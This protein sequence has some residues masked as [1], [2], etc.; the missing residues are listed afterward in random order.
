MDSIKFQ[1]GFFKLIYIDFVKI[2]SL[3]YL[4]PFQVQELAIVSLTKSFLL[5]ELAIESRSLQLVVA[6]VT[7]TSSSGKASHACSVF[8]FT[9]YTTPLA[10]KRESLSPESA[11]ASTTSLLSL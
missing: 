9:P 11:R 5:Q 1:L 6:G 4:W 10:P 7:G 8:N 2:L 3:N